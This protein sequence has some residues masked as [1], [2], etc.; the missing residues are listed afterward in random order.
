MGP[1]IDLRIKPPNVGIPMLQAGTV[2]KVVEHNPS[3]EGEATH[4]K[5]RQSLKRSL[6]SQGKRMLALTCA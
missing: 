6:V 5:N 3:T 4:V 2:A 1:T